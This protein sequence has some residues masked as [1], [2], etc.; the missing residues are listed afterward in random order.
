MNITCQNLDRRHFFTQVKVK[1]GQ[2]GPFRKNSPIVIKIGLV[3]IYVCILIVYCLSKIRFAS[4]LYPGRGQRVQFKKLL[5][6]E[7][8]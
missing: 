8:Q 3:I 1:V 7:I 6:D 2:R 4:F 5:A